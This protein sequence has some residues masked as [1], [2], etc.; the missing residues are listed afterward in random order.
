MQAALEAVGE[1]AGRALAERCARDR[2]PLLDQLEA[3][4]FV[5]KDVWGEA[6]RK[7][8]DNLRTNH[9]C[10]CLAL[11]VRALRQ[12]QYRLAAVCGEA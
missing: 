7:A 5:C 12:A 1:R 8:V 2:P 9:R 11:L 3:V 6:F 4:K 10:A